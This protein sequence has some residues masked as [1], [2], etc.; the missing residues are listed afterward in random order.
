[1]NLHSDVNL[2]YSFLFTDGFIDQVS[3]MLTFLSKKEEEETKWRWF[4]SGSQVV[5]WTPLAAVRPFFEFISI[6]ELVSI[7]ELVGETIIK[8]SSQ[9]DR[10]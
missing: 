2:D 6:I 9:T 10:T 4:P 1:M 8:T 7:V 3:C 5:H